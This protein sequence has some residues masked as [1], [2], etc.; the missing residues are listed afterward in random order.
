[1]MKELVAMTNKLT[2]KHLTKIVKLVTTPECE[3]HAVAFYYSQ[4][5][6]AKLRLLQ[7][8]GQLSYH[9]LMLRAEYAVDIN[10]NILIKCRTSLVDLL[11]KGLNPITE[12]L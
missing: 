6:I 11:D 3:Q 4:V 1:M 9:E 7:G 12:I 8:T 2:D 10:T 5:Q